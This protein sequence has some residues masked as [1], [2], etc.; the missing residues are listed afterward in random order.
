M[1]ENVNLGRRGTSVGRGLTWGGGMDIGDKCDMPGKD[2]I[3]QGKGGQRAGQTSPSLP[4]MSL[5]QS[6][7][8]R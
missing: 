8:S 4:V 2:G 5:F 1:G 3:D 7:N 6:D